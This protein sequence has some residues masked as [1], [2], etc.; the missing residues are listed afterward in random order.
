[1]LQQ[2]TVTMGH[3]FVNAIVNMHTPSHIQCWIEP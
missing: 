2:Q 3:L 1:M